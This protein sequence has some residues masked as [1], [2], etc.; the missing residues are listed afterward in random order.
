MNH[1]FKLRLLSILLV[2]TVFAQAAVTEKAFVESLLSKMTLEEKLGQMTLASGGGDPVI[3]TSKINVRIEIPK[4][5]C[6]AVYAAVQAD[7]IRKLQDLAMK[8]RLKIPM[9]FGYD[10]IHGFKTLFPIP[11]AQASSFNLSLI[12]R[13]AEISAIEGAS[14]G[15]NWYFGPMIDIARDARWGRVSEGPGE[16]PYLGSKIATEMVKGY[17]GNDL[18]KPTNVAACAKH[19]AGYGAP[20]AGKEYNTVIMSKEDLNDIYL[21][22]HKAA[23]DAGVASYMAAFNEI[24]GMPCSS[25]KYLLTDVLQKKWKFQGFVVSDYA[26]INGL[27]NHGVAEN[28]AEAAR[29]AIQSGLSMDMESC[30]Y[31]LK[32]V[33]NQVKNKQIDIAK[34]DDAV[35]RILTIKYRLGLFADPYK[36]C[37]STTNQLMLPEHIAAAREM[38]RQSIVLLKNDKETLPLKVNG[39]KIALIG[40]LANNKV[41]VFGTWIAQ[42]DTGKV[43]TLMQGLKNQLGSD[44]QLEYVK[45][46]EI[47]TKDTSYFQEAIALAQRSDIIVVALG[48]KWDMS[49]ESAARGIINIP[50]V[51]SDLLKALYATKKPLVLVLTNGRPLTLQEDVNYCDAIL[52]TWQ[53]GTTA[54]DAIADVLLGKYNPSAKLPVTFPRYVGQVPIYY[55]YKNTGIPANEA[56]RY[57]SKYLDIPFTPLFPF[58]FG[59]SYSTFEYSDISVSKQTSSINEEVVITCKLKNTGKV[60]GEEIAQLYIKDN[61]GELTRPVRELKGF[62]KV[63]LQPGETKII[64][65]KV[66]PSRD[67]TYTH[68]DGTQRADAGKFTVFVGGDSNAKLSIPFSVK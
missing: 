51:Q 49:G 6:G 42:G 25:S 24:N 4:G 44:T 59:L 9:L 40:P 64:T 36:Y 21:A 3:P 5:R 30:F 33:E 20:V 23:A 50:G 53:L 15:L 14:V 65:F 41:D 2:A 32:F 61:I 7:T 12:H 17:Q 45:G 47:D 52:E 27:I 11:L 39:K 60:A 16:D 8:S 10:V 31:N 62:E 26:S 13:A 35:R 58:G 28:E 68:I 43:V 18:S 19:F 54:G 34:I 46:C 56:F 57:N 55:A 48:E 63:M 22:P 1:F 66:I 67:L 38:S 29:L 37:K